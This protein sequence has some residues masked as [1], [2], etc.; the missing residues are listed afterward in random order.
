MPDRVLI[1]DDDADTR[2]SISLIARK[3]DWEVELAQG[4]QE[5][6][7]FLRLRGAD[8]I[9]CDL[10]MPGIDGIEFLRRLRASGRM[11][12][13]VMV[14]GH[15][16]VES[17]VEALRLGAFDY[18]SKPVRLGILRAVL[19]KVRRSLLPPEPDAGDRLRLEGESEAIQGVLE[20]IELAAP[21]RSTVLITGETGTGKEIVAELIHRRSPRAQGPLVRLN[22]AGLPENLVESELFGHERGAFTGADRTRAGRFEVAD[23]GTLFLDEVSEMSWAAQARLLRVLQVGEFERVGSSQ[24]RKTDVRLIAAT[25]QNLRELVD[26]KR[27]REDLYYRLHVIEIRIAPLREHRGDIPILVRSILTRLAVEAARAYPDV[28]ERVMRVFAA[29]S[30]PGNVRELEHVLEHGFILSKGGPLLP[31]HLPAEIRPERPRTIRI[32]VG[33][34]LENAEREI[35]RQTLRAVDDDKR[36][37][38]RLL[39]LSRS[40]L[41]RR[42]EDFREGAVDGDEP[43]PGS[44]SP[45]EPKPKPKPE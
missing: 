42:L 35:I 45:A 24:T 39:G 19:K 10:V 13:F 14:T 17:A 34:S 23:G 11:T 12:P 6:M 1:V 5:A 4:A 32:S 26:A 43:D 7:E 2:A 37:A 9:L 25:N 36:E 8:L 30:W 3:D 38:A 21:S 40:A 41:Y 44:S 27:F 15:A 33:T 18:V 28:S 29:Y 20:M 16:S 22:C 31:E